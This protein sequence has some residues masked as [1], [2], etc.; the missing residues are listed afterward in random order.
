VAS[1]TLGRSRD[2]ASGFFPSAGDPNFPQDSYNRAAEYGRSS[3]D[4]RH[5]LTAG[6]VWEVP[7][8]RQTSGVAGA[9]A[10]GWQLSA[11][12]TLHSGRPFTVALL[13]EFDNSN[14]GRTSLGFGAND[15]PNLVGDP[16][17]D[18]PSPDR[19]F[20]TA[21]FELP[22]FGSFGSAGRNIVEGPGY[23]NVNLAAMKFIP[24][25]KGARIQARLEVFNV[26]DRANFNGPDS[27]L[28]SPTFGQVLSA[29][30]PRRVQLGLKALF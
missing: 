3:F 4:V 20:D 11:V 28:G 13:P 9:L 24:L 17:L 25:G 12:A 22:S 10:R 2:D 26:F 1:Y 6:F 18:D 7:A 14:T 29:Q 15:R 16:V 21:A 8:G 30:S 23:A 19:W 27:F 5:K